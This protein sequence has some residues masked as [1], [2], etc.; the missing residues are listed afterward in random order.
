M[1]SDYWIPVINQTKLRYFLIRD[2]EIQSYLVERLSQGE[3][4]ASSLVIMTTLVTQS[5]RVVSS[6]A[7]RFTVLRANLQL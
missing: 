5:I 1:C 7:R 3:K 4:Q 2:A 6:F